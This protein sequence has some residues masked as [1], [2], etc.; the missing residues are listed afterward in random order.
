MLIIFVDAFPAVFSDKL[1]LLDKYFNKGSMAPR[2]GYSVNLHAEIFSGKT[3]L[4]L[5]YLG[6]FAWNGLEKGR[7]NKQS[8]FEEAISIF[9][10]GKLFRL[11]RLFQNKIFKMNLAYIPSA[12]TP[13]FKRIGKYPLTDFEP[14]TFL[15]TKNFS[16]FIADSIKE[17]FF[18]RDEMAFDNTMKHLNDDSPNKNVFVSLCGFDGLCHDFGANADETAKKISWL[19]TA[20][21]TL[22]VKYGDLYPNED[23]VILSDHGISDAEN[24]IKIIWPDHIAKR[25]GKDL[26]YFMDSLYLHVW[27][28]DDALLNEVNLYLSDVGGV[29]ILDADYRKKYDVSYKMFGNIMALCQDHFCF[30]PNFFGFRKLKSYHGY[31]PHYPNSQ[32]IFYSKSNDTPPVDTLSAYDWFM[33]RLSNVN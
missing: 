14:E 13:Y 31:K 4:E 21:E 15:K 1:P 26:F 16:C 28:E 17:G 11:V 5:G 19:D 3:P 7:A 18:K 24:E 25:I 9:A 32:C 20:I 30:N 6:E 8:L 27:C 22:T 12:M 2:L 33:T 23:I 10:R 29:D